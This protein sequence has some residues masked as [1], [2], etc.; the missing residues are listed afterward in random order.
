[1]ASCCD[2]V[3]FGI[4]SE[5]GQEPTGTALMTFD[6][7]T[8]P[9]LY[10]AVGTEIRS[11]ENFTIRYPDNPFE[12]GSGTLRVDLSPLSIAGDIR[13]LPGAT[14]TTRRYAFLAHDA[15]NTVTRI[16]VYGLDDTE[17]GVSDDL[18]L[19]YDTG[20]LGYAPNYRDAGIGVPSFFYIGTDTRASAFH[21]Y[22]L[23]VRRISLADVLAGN[24]AASAVDV[25]DLGAP[26]TQHLSFTDTFSVD[27]ASDNSIYIL[28]RNV[29]RVWKYRNDTL[30]DTIPLDYLET[31]DESGTTTGFPTHLST[32]AKCA[33]VASRSLFDPVEG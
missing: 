31:I 13:L 22:P 32:K 12:G 33:V 21:R 18:E 3:A 7:P 10:A 4:V 5:T 1:M 25:V 26:T 14:D 30:L 20:G 29:D 28:W 23:V 15:T 11:F 16:H 19:G 24:G 6:N 9:V 27:V 8:T 2:G 17:L